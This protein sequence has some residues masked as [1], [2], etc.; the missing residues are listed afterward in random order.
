MAEEWERVGSVEIY[1][2]YFFNLNVGRYLLRCWAPDNEEGELYFQKLKIA[3]FKE[4]YSYIYY[5]DGKSD[6]KL[7]ARQL[8]QKFKLNAIQVIIN[9]DGKVEEGPVMYADWP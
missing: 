8:L 1:T 6:Y 4:A 7:V 9:N 3:V 5:N 2:E